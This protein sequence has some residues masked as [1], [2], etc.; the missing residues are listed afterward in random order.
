MKRPVL[1]VRASTERPEVLG[2]FAELVS[3]TTAIGALGR[4]WMADLVV[5]HARLAGLAS[6]YGDGTA[7]ERI[8]SAIAELVA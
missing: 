5:V 2:T 3:D 6:P 8:A 1:V 4:E 7:G